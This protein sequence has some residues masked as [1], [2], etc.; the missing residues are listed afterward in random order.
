MPALL[1]PII[2]LTRGQRMT[3][4]DEAVIDNP[5]LNSPYFEPERHWPFDEDRGVISGAPVQGRRPSSYLTPIPGARAGAQLL[6]GVTDQEVV[7]RNELINDVRARVKAWR[8]G[9]RPWAEVTATTRKLLEHWSVVEGRERPLFFAQREA[10]ETAIWLTEVAPKEAPHI[11]SE[12]AKFGQAVSDGLPRVAHKMA[13]GTGKTVL[14]SLIIAWQTLNKA[15][16][17]QDA[18]FTDQ[19]LV[20][21]PGIT[22]RDR[23]RVLSPSEPD[24]YYDSLHL[25]PTSLR[26]DLSRAT[27]VVINYHQMMLR[28]KETL[29]AATKAVL[30]ADAANYTETER[31][32]V[33]RVLRPFGKRKTE[34][35]VLNDEAHH[36]YRLRPENVLLDPDVSRRGYRV[37]EDAEQSSSDLND[38]E[39]ARV[40]H[41]GL[42]AVNRQR[43]IKTVYD[44]S[45]TPFY[46][47][48]SGWPEGT[49]F[50]WVVSDFPLIEA[51]EAGLVK[52]PRVPV[53]DDVDADDP[54]FRALW[55]HVGPALRRIGAQ[56]AREGEPVIPAELEGAFRA[57]YDDYEGHYHQKMDG[58]EDDPDVTPP[59]FIVVADTTDRSNYLFRWMSGWRDAEGAYHHGVAPLFDNVVC[60]NPDHSREGA[61]L[62]NTVCSEKY[63]PRLRS[64]PL[65]LLV[66]SAALDRP[67]AQFPKAFRDAAESELER[68]RA[69]Y[70]A[71]SPGDQPDDA[72]ILREVMNTIGKP[73]RL[74]APIRL[75]VSV[76]MLTE[77]W[78]ANTVTHVLGVRA[79][80]TQLIC[81]Q[82]VGRALRR[83]SYEVNEEKKYPPE[84][85]DIY[86]VPWKLI[87]TAGKREGPTNTNPPVRIHP[88]PE[89]KDQTEIR[90]PRVV[91][92]RVQPPDQ[93]LVVDTFDD[94]AKLTIEQATWAEVIDVT[95]HGAIATLDALRSLRPQQVAFDLAYRISQRM[96]AGRP[97]SAFDAVGDD[98]R[99]P[100]F[101]GSMP[102]LFPQ[103]LDIVRRWLAECLHLRGNAFL[104]LVLLSQHRAE[105]VDRIFGQI[106]NAESARGRAVV[107][108]ILGPHGAVGSTGQMNP[109]ATTR[110]LEQIHTT[111]PTK[112]H[113]NRV[114][115][116]SGWETRFAKQLETMD[117][118]SRY[119]KNDHIDFTIPYV[120]DGIPRSYTPD[121]I[122]HLDDGHED[123]LQVL[124]EVSGEGRREKD[125]K[126]MTTATK[127]ANAVNA[128]G[129]FG[130]WAF[131]ELTTINADTPKM[132]RVKASEW[133]DSHTP[134]DIQQTLQPAAK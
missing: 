98:E 31:E 44:L 3:E 70:A 111:A 86:G 34:I 46:I 109:W 116:H 8:S 134:G 40:W 37:V 4:F 14:M 13:T 2:G 93:E 47:S 42:V 126:T 128:D 85:A 74:G 64:R 61:H 127:W 88:L 65:S 105:A 39:Q 58:R 52:I 43:G 9:H 62:T 10:I 119:V 107:L 53:R 54:A 69:E 129:R 104:Q 26:D 66:D 50:Q 77:G 38:D 118:V 95:G 113:I 11:V 73:G 17:P 83:V 123:P 35:I 133:R 27:V 71:R 89:R 99:G 131:V 1:G 55:Q 32:M 102:W 100:E 87:P 75:V 63:N 6:L 51:V 23:L 19:F 122:V 16:N 103:V 132:L 20:V 90:F 81:E 57:L 18:R 106:A 36:C 59:V 30:G 125:V 97:E 82:V 130:R 96:V 92:Y 49:L 48:G 21:S 121:F 7:R 108:P 12:L 78:D 120:L 15:R 117:D 110:P 24:N 22:I 91:G 94:D 76:S 80:S 115:G 67:G 72:E 101:V 84:Y 28:Q 68:F 114:V 45:A 60:E 33:A 29:T 56:E 79:F 41:T 112:C 124:V 25:I 5:I